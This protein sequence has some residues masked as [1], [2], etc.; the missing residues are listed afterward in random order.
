[1]SELVSIIIPV[2]NSENYIADTIKSAIDQTWPNKEIIIVDD[3]ST[4]NSLSISKSF[5]CEFVKVYTQKNGGAA[6]AR[7]L[8]LKYAKGSFIQFLDADDI[9][10]LNKIEK[11]ATILKQSP[12]K[13]AVCS[14]V[15][16][17]DGQ[18]H[19]LC[20]PSNY[21]QKFLFS[22]DDPADFLINLWGGYGRGGS[23]IQTNAWLIPKLIILMALS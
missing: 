22:S 1:M 15:H 6:L 3:G 8:G 21:E 17:Q 13:V 10:S 14:T 19:H 9:L 11:Q 5:E 18:N 20:L 2:Y 23:M 16:F 7:N 4:D 12:S